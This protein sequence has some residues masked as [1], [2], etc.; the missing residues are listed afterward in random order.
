MRKSK[1]G[2]SRKITKSFSF[3]ASSSFKEEQT[4]S[5]IS[6]VKTFEPSSAIGLFS[7]L[8]KNSLVFT[9]FIHQIAPS[10]SYFLKSAVAKCKATY[11]EKVQSSR[12]VGKPWCCA[13][14]SQFQIEFPGEASRCA[15]FLKLRNKCGSRSA[16]FPPNRIRLVLRSYALFDKPRYM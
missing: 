9:L 4:G 7:S 16:K 14:A 5:S 2:G 3:S 10:M 13:T 15:Y 8:G 12:R 1:E 6:A 11:G